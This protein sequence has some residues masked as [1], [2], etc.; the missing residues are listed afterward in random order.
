MCRVHARVCLSRGRSLG[1]SQL[2]KTVTT[3]TNTRT[4]KCM[5]ARQGLQGKS[6]RLW[7]NTFF[8]PLFDAPVPHQSPTHHPH[9]FHCISL[10]ISCPGPPL[11]NPPLPRRCRRCAEEWHMQIYLIGW[12]IGMKR[13]SLPRMLSSP[14]SRPLP[15][16][17]FTLFFLSFF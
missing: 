6:G 2:L 17:C 1:L 10:S 15:S 9:I 5:N 11:H 7:I 3:H 16:P 12:K 14:T 13:G 4:Y 8:P